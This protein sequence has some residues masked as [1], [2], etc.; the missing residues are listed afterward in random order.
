MDRFDVIVIGTGGMGAAALMHLAARGMRVCGLDR[1]PPGHDRGS[2]HGQ[3]RLIRLAYF[4]HPDYVPLLRRAYGLWRDLEAATGQSLLIESGL[5]MAGPAAGQVIAGALTSA[6]IHSLEIEPLTAREAMA[7]WPSIRLPEEWTAVHEAQAG[8]LF[9]EECVRAHAAEAVR[10]GARIDHGS[11]VRNWQALERGDG[12]SHVIVETDGGRYAADR[13][14]ITAGAWATDLL[15]LPALPLRVLRKS[16]FWYAADARV[17]SAYAAGSLPCFAFDGPTGFFYGFPAIDGR[18]VKIAE[19]TGGI[20]VTDPRDVNRAIDAHERER[21]ET[22]IATHLPALEG[23]L[24]DHTTC[25]YTMSPD[26]HFVVG[27]H[28]QHPCVAI[29]AGFSGHG[30]KFA[31]VM[32][33]ILADLAIDR[34]TTHPIGFL[35]PLRPT[36]RLTASGSEPP[37]FLTHILDS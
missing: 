33:E 28:P 4:E 16:L 13:L 29:A 20:P 9:V 35:S 21:M 14:V 36:S 34:K 30:F 31:S 24:T 5:L 22:V 8:Y 3:T 19:H 1:F 23:R 25:L 15:K 32:G 6:A 26:G 10:L 18:G 37:Q 7:R 2:S 11:A 12:S 27:V 17:Q